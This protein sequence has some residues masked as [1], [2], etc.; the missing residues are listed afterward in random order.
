[1]TDVS[2][3]EQESALIETNSPNI[4]NCKVKEKKRRK[5]KKTAIKRWTTFFFVSYSLVRRRVLLKGIINL[6]TH[7]NCINIK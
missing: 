4:L 2:L 5:K 7:G 6:S 1:M 3:V